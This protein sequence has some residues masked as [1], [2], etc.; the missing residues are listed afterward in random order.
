M[1]VNS[2]VWILNLFHPYH[3]TINRI[4]LESIYF[5]E[6]ED[7]MTQSKQL[8]IVREWEILKAINDAETPEQKTELLKEWGGQSPLN[9]VLSFN[10][11]DNLKFDLPEGVPPYKRDEATH[12]DFQGALVHQVKKL[13]NCLPNVKM[14]KMRKENIFISVLESI[15]PKSADIVLAMKD[16]ALQEL[17]PNITK[18]LVKECFPQ[19]VR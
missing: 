11:S 14:P 4:K 3:T 15:P 19:Y 13:T 18:E 1:W 17:Y 10:F 8:S 9:Y 5:A 16:K 7:I 12:T 6:K 2:D